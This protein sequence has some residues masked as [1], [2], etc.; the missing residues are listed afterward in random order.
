MPLATR[1]TSGAALV[2]MSLIPVHRYYDDPREMTPSSDRAFVVDADINHHIDRVQL[3][4][5]ATALPDR[6]EW[7]N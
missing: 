5:R 6:D 2:L 4:S 3:I 7:L 1:L